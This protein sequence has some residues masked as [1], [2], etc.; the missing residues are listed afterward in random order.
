MS[1]PHE[2]RQG[3]ALQQLRNLRDVSCL[4]AIKLSTMRGEPRWE[5]ARAARAFSE[6]SPGLEFVPEPGCSVSLWGQP[7]R[8]RRGGLPDFTLL[9]H[10]S[11]NIYAAVIVRDID[12]ATVNH[13][14]IKFVEQKLDA[15]LL[16]VPKNLE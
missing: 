16:R 15:P 14:G 10:K 12:L 3:L 9:L 5:A 1:A 13:R 11:V 6:I 2:H 8:K 7:R 4:T